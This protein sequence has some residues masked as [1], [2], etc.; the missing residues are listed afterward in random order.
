MREY[1]LTEEIA[2]WAFEV[3]CRVSEGWEIAFTN[4]TAGPWK[5][6]KAKNTAGELGE[7][8]RFGSNE[9][10]PDIVLINDSLELIVIF[11]AKDSLHKLVAATQDEKSVDVVEDLAKVFGEMRDNHYWGD[12]YRYTVINGLLW[13]A[14]GNETMEAIESVFD[15]YHNDAANCEHFVVD[16]LIGVQSNK[17]ETGEIKCS[18][19]AKPYNGCKRVDASVVAST[20]N[21]PL[22][23]F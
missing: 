5:T 17:Q 21:M 22:I 12:R 4:P 6:I 7:V 16:Y 1:S 13:G 15:Q 3:I 2:R 20:L 23:V 14:E 19:Y 9:K 18:M 11:E 10:R 8:Y